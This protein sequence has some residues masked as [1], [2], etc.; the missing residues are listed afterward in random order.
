MVQSPFGMGGNITGG[1]VTAWDGDKTRECLRPLEGKLGATSAGNARLLKL[2][3]GLPASQVGQ[4]ALGDD[5]PKQIDLDHELT[6][7]VSPR[8]VG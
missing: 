8:E 6:C 5:S 3:F 2:D 1:K 4:L 7:H